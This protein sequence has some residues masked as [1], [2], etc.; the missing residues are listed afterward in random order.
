MR[1]PRS[2]VALRAAAI[3]LML[4]L[5]VEPRSA[6]ADGAVVSR[7]EEAEAFEKEIRP[8]LAGT[9]AKC[10]G[11]EKQKGGLRVDSRKALLDGGGS[12]PAVVPGRPSES[13]LLDAVRHRGELEMPPGRKLRDAQIER[14]NA[15]SRRRSL[16]RRGNC[17]EP[18]RRCPTPS[19]GLPARRR[20]HPAEGPSRRV[21]PDAD[22]RLH[23]GPPGGERSGAVADGRSPHPDPSRDL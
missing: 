18:I 6:G 2:P 17:Q 20:P 10:H 14:W 5:G 1:H 4:G 7:S 3:V 19:L 21:V 11:A 8:L 23:P 16:A 15:G 9:C 13:L 22:R 12:G